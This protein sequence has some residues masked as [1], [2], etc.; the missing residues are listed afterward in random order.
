MI[1]GKMVLD[2]SSGLSFGAFT[3][4]LFAIFS[5]LHPMKEL[6]K[7]YT[8]IRRA[9]VSLSRV[10]EILDLEPSVKSLPIL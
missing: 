3:A 5:I 8:E 10:F 6:T 2:P 7:Y 9:M 1:G 4:F